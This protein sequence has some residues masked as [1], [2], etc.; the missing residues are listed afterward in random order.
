MTYNSVKKPILDI[1]HFSFRNGALC[2][3]LKDNIDNIHNIYLESVNLRNKINKLQLKTFY[4]FSETYIGNIH[5]FITDFLGLYNILDNKKIEFVRLN[6]PDDIVTLDISANSDLPNMFVRQCTS[7]LYTLIYYPKN[8][9]LKTDAGEDKGKDYYSRY[10]SSFN[11]DQ[12]FHHDILNEKEYYAYLTKIGVDDAKDEQADFDFRSEEEKVYDSLDDEDAKRDAFPDLWIEE[13]CH[14]DY[15]S[16]LNQ[17][18][19]ANRYEE[20]E[21]YIEM[22]H[23]YSDIKVIDFKLDDI[24]GCSYVLLLIPTILAQDKRSQLINVKLK[25]IHFYDDFYYMGRKDD[26]MVTAILKT[27]WSN[28]NIEKLQKETGVELI[29]ASEF[30]KAIIYTNIVYDNINPL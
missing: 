17:E 13:K 6:G 7:S 27:P 1:L 9:I 29:A 14:D 15:E 25:T 3:Y 30:D 10:L 26:I 2:L 20:E 8:N 5:V 16:S 19:M 12:I 18:N 11:L 21:K 24:D 23:A 4:G 28:V 22:I